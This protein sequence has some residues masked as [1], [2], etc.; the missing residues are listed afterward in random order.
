[1]LK[2]VILFIKYPY[3]AGTIGTIWLG[4]AILMALNKNLDGVHIVMINMFASVIIAV[5]GFGGKEVN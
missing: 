2:E 3:T 1:M 5:V 4:S